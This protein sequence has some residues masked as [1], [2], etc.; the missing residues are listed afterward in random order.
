MD[1]QDFI[2]KK[3][4]SVVK[5]AFHNWCLIKYDCDGVCHVDKSGG[6]YRKLE[7]RI[8]KRGLT[9]KV[10]DAV[11]S[12]IAV[13]H[14][15]GLMCEYVGEPLSVWFHA[16]A[17]KADAPFKKESVLPSEESSSGLDW[18]GEDEDGELEFA[19]ASIA[20]RTLET[21]SQVLGKCSD[22]MKDLSKIRAQKLFT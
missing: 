10:S 22:I 19:M 8:I 20:E 7:G 21:L 11:L 2:T 15:A 13:T 1:F 9:L 17:S 6:L 12:E 16:D 18:Y 5:Q 3:T 14:Q 4:D